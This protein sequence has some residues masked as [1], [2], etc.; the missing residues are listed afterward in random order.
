M[1]SALQGIFI[2]ILCS[3]SLAE[4]EAHHSVEALK[5]K[6][7]LD[8]NIHRLV[9]ATELSR[10]IFRSSDYCLKL[11]KREFGVTPYAYQINRKMEL[12]KYFLSK[13]EMSVEEIAESL[14]YCDVHYF[15]NLFIN[16]CGIRPS[17]YRK[18]TAERR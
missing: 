12:A 9:S 15:S 6:E 14:G 11:F 17:A 10:V 3:L 7:F 5:M 2:E 4:S 13:T 18:S 1:Q 8:E 16:K